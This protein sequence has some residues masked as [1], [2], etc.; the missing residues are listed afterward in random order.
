MYSKVSFEVPLD[1]A[2]KLYI[3]SQP[4]MVGYTTCWDWACDR[5]FS[6]PQKL[7]VAELTTTYSHLDH[8][9]PI[10]GG[11]PLHIAGVDYVADTPARVPDDLQCVANG[12][13]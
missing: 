1:R 4:S 6:K 3:V 7:A 8:V 9:R 12:H 10:V 11:P 13:L 5:L 2:V